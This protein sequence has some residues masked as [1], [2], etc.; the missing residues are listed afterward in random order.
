[1][2]CAVR[3]SETLVG[4]S[5]IT[6]VA[7]KTDGKITDFSNFCGIAAELVHRSRPGEDVSA[8]YFGPHPTEPNSPAQGVIADST[9]KSSLEPNI[10]FASK[11][12]RLRWS[13][14]NE[15]TFSR[16]VVEYRTGYTSL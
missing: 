8:A 9:Q 3:I 4:M 7:T 14:V 10:G 12:V 13:R 5:D 1:M 16:S 11:I 6:V 2:G 15:T